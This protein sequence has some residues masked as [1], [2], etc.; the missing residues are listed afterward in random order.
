MPSQSSGNQAPPD[1]D[2][3]ASCARTVLARLVLI[4]EAIKNRDLAD[5]RLVAASAKEDIDEI[6]W[7]AEG[8]E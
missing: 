5:L 6:V 1:W 4:D 8:H 7:Y 3:A 2:T